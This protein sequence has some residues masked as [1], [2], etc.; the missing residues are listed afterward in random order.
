[1]KVIRASL[2]LSLTQAY[3]IIGLEGKCS[4][5]NKVNIKIKGLFD[6]CWGHNN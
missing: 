3:H 1:M 6:W 5:I 2:L 4:N